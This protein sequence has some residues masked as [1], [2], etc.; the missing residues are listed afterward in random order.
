MENVGNL[1]RRKRMSEIEVNIE[2]TDYDPFLVDA[3]EYERAGLWE[4]GCYHFRLE[5][6]EKRT[7]QEIRGGDHE[8]ETYNALNLRF[9]AFE[10]A[11]Y[12]E[13]GYFTG[14]IE[15]IDFTPSR[16]LELPVDGPYKARGLRTYGNLCERLLGK[17]DG[18]MKDSTTG[19]YSL[20]DLGD[21]LISGEV[22]NVVTN[23]QNKRGKNIGRWNDAM[24]DYFPKEPVRKIKK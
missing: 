19:R 20:S 14:E 8:G 18:G 4:P 16:F 7:D 13:E 1:Q 15:K 21:S 2:D 9:I 10:K 24:S 17:K 6:I 23:Y 22:W 3:E 12:N 5:S 11:V